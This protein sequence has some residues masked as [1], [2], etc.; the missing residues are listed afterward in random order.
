MRNTPLFLSIL[1][2]LS[3]VRAAYAACP[4]G[5]VYRSSNYLRTLLAGSPNLTVTSESSE[6]RLLR[7]VMNLSATADISGPTGSSV[8]FT[9]DGVLKA[10]GRYS[11]IRRGG[12]R[13]IRINS[14]QA[15]IFK[16]RV[17]IN[18]EL[19]STRDYRRVVF[20]D[21]EIEY[22]CRGSRLTLITEVGGRRTVLSFRAE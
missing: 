11:L 19:S 10:R 7:G 1:F 22:S 20:G 18:G 5:R 17:F 21:R 3:L 13:Y 6:L 14:V 9:G 15:D 12:K 16:T 8:I 2:A 4:E